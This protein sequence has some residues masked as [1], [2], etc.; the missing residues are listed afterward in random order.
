[1]KMEYMLLFSMNDTTVLWF[2]PGRQLSLIQP[3]ASSPASAGWG[4][5]LA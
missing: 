1:M 4:S 2:N 3:L 5:K